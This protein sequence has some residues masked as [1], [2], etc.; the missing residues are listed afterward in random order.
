MFTRESESLLFHVEGRW[1]FDDV[2]SV[3]DVAN[4]TV[5]FDKAEGAEQALDVIFCQFAFNDR[6][7]VLEHESI[8]LGLILKDAH[9]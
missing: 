3:G 9:L 6:I 7:V 8:I 1:S 5:L 4:H 2:L